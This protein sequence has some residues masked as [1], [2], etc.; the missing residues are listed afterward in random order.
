MEGGEDEGA[1]YFIT[2]YLDGERFDTWLARC[3]PLPPWLALQTISQIIEG[4][5]VLAPH[6][7]L[8]AGVEAF[9]TAGFP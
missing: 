5:C 7:R 8:L 2:E 6:P 1:N 3:N 4:L 9:S